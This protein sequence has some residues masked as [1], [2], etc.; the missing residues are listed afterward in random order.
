MVKKKKKNLPA[1]AGDEGSI[2]WLERSLGVGNGNPLQYFCLKNPMDRGARSP[3]RLQRV[4]YNCAQHSIAQNSP[5]CRPGI[6]HLNTFVM[7]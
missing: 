4:R 2:P 1:N 5:K 6:F 7:L 3:V